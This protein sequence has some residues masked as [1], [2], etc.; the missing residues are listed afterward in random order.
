MQIQFTGH[1]VELTDPLRQFTSDKFDHLKRFADHIIHIHVTFLV[2]KT[3]HIAKA[4]V[5][6]ANTDIFASENSADLYSAVD[7]LVENLKRQLTKHKEKQDT[8]R[9]RT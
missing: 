2:N 1:H 9:D 6:L 7:L 5:K 8:H 4:Q 3:N